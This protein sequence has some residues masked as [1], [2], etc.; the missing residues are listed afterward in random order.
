MPFARIDDFINIG[1][2]HLNEIICYNVNSLH[3]AKLQRTFKENALWKKSK[4]VT[5]YF[6]M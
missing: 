2:K 6:I 5:Q 4:C 1:T 3:R